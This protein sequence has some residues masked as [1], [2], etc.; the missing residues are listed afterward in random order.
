MIFFF[1]EKFEYCC[2]NSLLKQ[3]TSTLR[4]LTSIPHM[5][6]TPGDKISADYIYNEWKAQGLDSIQMIDYDVFL[7]FPDDYKF[8]KY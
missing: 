1:L 7:S 8:N 6:G 3:F 5:A 4:Y 2:N